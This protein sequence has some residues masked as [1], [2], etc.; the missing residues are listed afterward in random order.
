M[1]LFRSPS[2]ERPSGHPC[3]H[4]PAVARIHVDLAGGDQAII[5]YERPI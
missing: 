4:Q 3:S 1:E 2:D 5:G